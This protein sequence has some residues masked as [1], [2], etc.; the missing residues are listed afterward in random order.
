MEIG[1]VARPLRIDLP[2]GWYHLTSCGN[3][4]GRI[5]RDDT[6]RTHSLELLEELVV[7]F[8][9]RDWALLLGQRE[10]GLK[11]GELGELCGGLDYRTVGGAVKKAIA[12]VEGDRECQ[13]AY[14][15][16]Q[17]ALTQHGR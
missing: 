9:W 13:R 2:G 6:D 5:Y 8:R 14:A 17:K 7:R 16:V 1:C 11:L 3:E 15:S 4:R 12:R 10:C